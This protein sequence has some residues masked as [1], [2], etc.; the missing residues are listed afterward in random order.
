MLGKSRKGILLLI[1]VPND[2]WHSHLAHPNLHTRMPRT[3]TFVGL[4][5]GDEEFLAKSDGVVWLVQQH[6]KY[7]RVARPISCH[8]MNQ[9]R[10]F[11]VTMLF[12]GLHLT[13]LCQECPKSSL[14]I[15]V[16]IELK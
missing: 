16:A 9:L 12:V 11:S 8:L 1:P 7:S 13:F 3:L 2:P 5:I 4:T 10:F 14:Q 6:G 15:D